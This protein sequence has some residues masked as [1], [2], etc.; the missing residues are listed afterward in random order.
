VS[1]L[2]RAEATFRGLLEASPDA[3]VV[4]ERDGTIRLVNSHTE[5]LFGYEPDELVGAPV[6]ILVPAAERAAHARHR[7]RY[8]EDPHRRP[9][10]LGLELSGVRKDGSEFPVEI[11]L[12][13]IETET[14]PR[15]VAA[16][17]DVTPRAEARRALNA[18]NE[19]LEAFSYSVSH[20]LRA[21][22]RQ[23][24]GFARLLEEQCAG[25][26]DA[27]GRHYLERIQE[28][29]RHMDRL[30]ADLLHLAHLGRSELRPVRVSLDAMV[31]EVV[32]E[33]RAEVG[34]REIV[35]KIGRLPEVLCDPGLMR[36]AFT[37]LLSNAL[38]YTRPRVR[39]EV[40]VAQRQGL[41][42]TTIMIRDNGVGFDAAR[43][44]KLFGVFQRFHSAEDF[45]GEGVGLATVRRIVRRHGGEVW[46]ESEPDA[47]AA[48]FVRLPLAGTQVAW[49]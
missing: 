20:D 47:G 29:A 37:N 46:A 45:E 43:A 22:I 38:K 21:P 3:I 40:E 13:P 2:R 34:G 25:A 24:D 33:L 5:Q 32:E 30:V 28:S 17:R 36:I 10:G 12:C 19:E 26:L 23:I 8:G 49:G 11:S 18:A 14:G 42:G 31:A 9:M 44:S 35:W 1:P 16:V 6:D 15:V 48:F 39:A 7:E 41:G 27:S 4:A